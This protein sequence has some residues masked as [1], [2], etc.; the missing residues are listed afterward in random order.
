MYK[1]ILVPLDGT[2]HDA[3][4]L[5]HVRRLARSN[6]A[7]LLLIQLHRVLKIEDPFMQRIQVEPG[8]AAYQAKE[9]ANVY[10]PKLEE[11]IRNDGIEV[12]TEFLL[13]HEHEADAIVGYAEEKGCD[14]IAFTN[15]LTAGL[16]RW[17]FAN[18]EEKVQRRS[19]VPILLVPAPKGK[20]T[21]S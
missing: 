7:A 8:S 1:K 15:Q 2:A 6:G 17:F 13:V 16:G 14:L 3:V 5:E 4:V 10:L 12:S 9:K 19:S 11:S 21:T 20:E 18:I